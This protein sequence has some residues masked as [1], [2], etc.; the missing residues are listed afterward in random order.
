MTTPRPFRFGVVAG[1]PSS[2]ADWLATARSVEALGYDTL[3]LPDTAYTPSPFPALA[4]AAAATSTLRVG[5]WVLAAPFRTPAAVVRETAALQLLSGGRFE[6]GIG[7]GRPDAAREAQMLGQEWG[8][9]GDRIARLVD[10]VT[11]VRAQVSPVPRVAVAAV[12]RRML[13]AGHHADTIALALPPDA[14][15]EPVEQVADLDRAGGDESELTLQIS[16]VAGRLVSYLARQGFGPD[17]LRGA[18]GVLEGD[19]DAMAEALLELRRRTGVS[20]VCVAAEHA[21]LFAPVRQ[22]LAST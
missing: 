15:V 1:R 13:A 21:E 6:L 8:S 3:L 22:A 17:G 12:G 2:G 10:T 9:V 20:Y 11:A 5:P 7:T 18:A 16:G 14:W 4:A 19:P